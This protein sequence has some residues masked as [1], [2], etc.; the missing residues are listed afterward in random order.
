MLKCSWHV[1][2]SMNVCTRCL[3]LQQIQKIPNYPTEYR[4]DVC[5][6]YRESNYDFCIPHY[7]VQYT[8]GYA[9]NIGEL[10][11]AS[12]A[13]SVLGTLAYPFE[14]SIYVKG[15]VN[16]DGSFNVADI[17][18][19]RN[20]LICASDASLTDWQAGD[21]NADGRLDV[22]DLILMRKILIPQ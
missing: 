20:W 9:N 17:V 7:G 14:S 1:T 3:F 13:I 12:D 8:Y 5:L 18:M 15:D 4:D 16:S 2:Y 21:L 11:A 22:F 10:T 19:L 6:Y